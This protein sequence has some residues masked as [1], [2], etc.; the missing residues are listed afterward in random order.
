MKESLLTLA[1]AAFCAL[2]LNA[3]N[4]V[5]VV[6]GGDEQT[7]TLDGDKLSA[8]CPE[9]KQLLDAF[10]GL[11]NTLDSIHDMAS[12]DAAISTLEGQMKHIQSLAPMV[13]NALDAQP[14]EKRSELSLLMLGPA[15]AL[16]ESV[17]K[18]EQQNF[19]GSKGLRALLMPAQNAE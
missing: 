11:C 14:A 15:F 2:P 13:N 1:L 4:K 17:S 19:Y 12:A 8:E 5:T 3:Q 18:L 6:S 7:I 10:E 16:A 9:L